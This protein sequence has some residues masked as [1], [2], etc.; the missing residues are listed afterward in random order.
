VLEDREVSIALQHAILKLP[1]HQRVPIVLYHFEQ[2]SYEQMASELAVPLAKVKT[3]IHRG[4][5]KLKAILET[6]DIR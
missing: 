1:S 5:L 4:R 3:D 6:S 2:M